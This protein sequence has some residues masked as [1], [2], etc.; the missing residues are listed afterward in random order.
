MGAVELSCAA[1]QPRRDLL[2]EELRSQEKCPLAPVHR[3]PKLIPLFERDARWAP[4]GLGIRGRCHQ[5]ENPESRDPTMTK[6][7]DPKLTRMAEI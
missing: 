1:R 4:V 7:K 6:N 2:V 3:V 5:R